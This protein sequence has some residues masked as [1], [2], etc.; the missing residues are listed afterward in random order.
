MAR[1]KSAMVKAQAVQDRRDAYLRAGAA[2][3]L[4]AIATLLLF[5]APARAQDANTSD[6][7]MPQASI[8]L[9]DPLDTSGETPWYETFSLSAGDRPAVAMN[10]VTTIDWESA[11]GRWGFTVGIEENPAEAFEYDDL[12]AS[13]FFNIGERF[14]VGTQLRWTAPED[15]VIGAQPEER[16]PEVKFESALRF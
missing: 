11:E 8:E 1:A 7:A 16:A 13:A 10:D 5:A 2:F 4:L 15:L 12:S 14:R 3:C 9:P 6:A